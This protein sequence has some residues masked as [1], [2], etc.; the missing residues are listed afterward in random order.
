MTGT[1]A[2]SRPTLHIRPAR[3]WLNDPNGICRVDGTWHVFFQYREAE[4]THGDICW[5][6]VSSPDLLRW[7][8]RPIALKP[9]PGGPDAAGCW[10]GCM[11]L[12]DGPPTAVYTA[13]RDHPAT[14][15]VVLAHSDRSLLEWRQED[16]SVAAVPDLPGVR[17]VRDPFV[18]RHGGRR[19]A[20]QGAGSV[21]GSPCL[22][23]HDCT[24]LT[25][26]RECGTL[27]TSEDPL[28]A[29]FAPAEIWECPNLVRLDDGWLLVLSLWRRER[30]VDLLEGVRW[31]TGTLR[32]HGPSLS[33]VP[34]AG[35]VLDHGPA[36]YAAHLLADGGRILA[37]GWAKETA[38][39]AEEI[40]TSRWAGV[41]SFPREL[42]W[43]GDALT[44]RPAAE[45][46][47]LRAG[48]LPLDGLWPSAFELVVRGPLTL[49]AGGPDAPVA[50]EIEGGDSDP[51]RVLVDGDLVEAFAGGT[52][53][54]TRVRLDL[55]GR[56]H[57]EADP[58][59]TELHRLALPPPGT[60]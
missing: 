50:V 22:V 25:R 56:W 41:L 57:L 42:G 28:L 20:V 54:T 2:E 40:R 27:L 24:D 46:T 43:E 53:Y 51:A 11:V 7:D 12:D 17:E 55:H 32:G 9:R 44:M 13:L 23:L 15:T 10:S 19:Y 36:W 26:W 31:F 49:R 52:A 47:R 37:W 4:T 30:G 1:R 34:V 16:T 3:G 38:R 59:R 18:F 45:L 6:H 48:R 5:A 33:F 39:T 21:G 35:G 8:A 60:G 29:R 14:A 58:A